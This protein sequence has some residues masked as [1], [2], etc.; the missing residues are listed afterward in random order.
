MRL[1]ASNLLLT[2]IQL[3]ELM[4]DSEAECGQVASS[5]EDAE[6]EDDDG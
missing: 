2:S 5:G 6:L 3:N 4:R 1:N